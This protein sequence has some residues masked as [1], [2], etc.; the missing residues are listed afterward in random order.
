MREEKRTRTESGENRKSSAYLPIYAT[1]QKSFDHIPGKPR[2][3]PAIALLDLS[4]DGVPLLSSN[5]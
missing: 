3:K 1:I 4:N 5:P 2:D